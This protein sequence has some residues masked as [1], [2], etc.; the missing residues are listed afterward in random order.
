MLHQAIPI[1]ECA[2]P[3]HAQV[4]AAA[5]AADPAL[6]PLFRA[7]LSAQELASLVHISLLESYADDLV[8]GICHLNLNA[9][10]GSL[11]LDVRKNSGL[12]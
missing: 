2:W 9:L 1:L 6:L 12:G 11:V 4:L 10:W 5:A 8:R 7:V 3:H